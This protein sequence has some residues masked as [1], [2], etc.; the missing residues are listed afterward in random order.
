MCKSVLT[1]TAA[2]Y[3]VEYDKLIIGVGALSN[4]FNVPGVRKHCFFLKV[5]LF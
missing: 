4:T 2:E 1:E 3:P 5:F